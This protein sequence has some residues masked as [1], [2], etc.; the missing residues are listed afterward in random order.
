MR[1]RDYVTFDEFERVVD[2]LR[3][4]ISLMA[5]QADVD[6]ITAQITQVST[7]LAAAKTSLQAEID[8][9]A[10]ANPGVDLSGLQAAV[11]P[12]DAAVQAVG[13]LVP[14]APAP[15]AA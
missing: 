4:R 14:D 9:L 5:T 15:P 13:G 11:A 10:V 12:L 2:Q 8:K 7:D 1:R 6:A 3:E